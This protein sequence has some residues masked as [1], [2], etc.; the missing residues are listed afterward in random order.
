MSCPGVG[1]RPLGLVSSA[2]GPHPALGGDMSPFAE[3]PVPGPLSRAHMGTEPYLINLLNP[4]VDAIKGPAVCN[5]VDQDRTLG[6][7]GG[8][9]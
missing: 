9:G 2:R 1:L 3:A 4:P 5:V 6:G 8:P 7:E